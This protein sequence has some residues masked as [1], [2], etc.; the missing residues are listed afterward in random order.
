MSVTVKLLKASAIADIQADLEASVLADRQL[1]ETARDE[2]VSAKDIS[3]TKASEAGAFRNEAETFK[4]TSQTNANQTIS[5]AAQVAS[6]KID[7]QNNKDLSL[8]Y[9]DNANASAIAAELSNTNA[10]AAAANATAVSQNQSTGRASIPASILLDMA[11]TRQLD[12]RITFTRAS[13]ATYFDQSGVLKTA[14]V[15]EPRFC[16]DRQTGESLGLL[17]EGS[18]VNLLPYSNDLSNWTNF[19]HPT[20]KN[21]VATVSSYIDDK[22]GIVSKV[23]I[24]VG[25][26]TGFILTRNIISPNPNGIFTMSIYLRSDET[27]TLKI[28]FRSDASIGSSI[29]LTVNL[30]KSWTRF[31]FTVNNTGVAGNRGFQI[32]RDTVTSAFSFYACYAQIEESQS[33]STAIL[34]TTTSATRAADIPS[35]K[36]ELNA[37]IKGKEGTW[38]GIVSK[39]NSLVDGTVVGTSGTQAYLNTLAAG[40]FRAI[41]ST[42]ISATVGTSN[43]KLTKGAVSLGTASKRIVADNG[44]VVSVSTNDL[45][46]TPSI[47]LGSLNGTSS[48]LNG[49]IKKIA[50]YPFAL[51][52]AEIKELTSVKLGGE[53]ANQFPTNAD[54]APFAFM[55]YKSAAQLRLRAEMNFMGAGS[56]ISYIIR[57]PYKFRM[58]IVN[59]N[60]STVATL[61]TPPADTVYLADTNYTLLHNAPVGT[62][63]T[64]E[65]LP[66]YN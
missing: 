52:D 42:P 32:L 49:Y 15:N 5:D 3:V 53:S 55:P 22:M 33:A 23:S 27:E 20:S 9:K 54:L 62:S 66:F 50:Y 10:T 6:D 26:G 41:D 24:A 60:G 35:F 7:V 18:S 65:I 17:I 37:L 40:G 45:P 39:K 16:F 4:S 58:N 36:S 29:P 56:Q 31:T 21:S 28:Y 11:N 19:Y 46:D 48:F 2:S 34:T 25:G 38:L 64:V 61:P 8:A 51:S 30:T 44:T 13:P 43:A 14:G 12:P 59:S 63:L 1:A 57:R 47:F